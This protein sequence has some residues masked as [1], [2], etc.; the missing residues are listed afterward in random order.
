VLEIRARA[1][2]PRRVHYAVSAA[3]LP[4][5]NRGLWGE[6]ALMTSWQTVN[7]IELPPGLPP[8]W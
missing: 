6:A 4:R 1:S 5:Q 3:R 8:T 2:A 7:I